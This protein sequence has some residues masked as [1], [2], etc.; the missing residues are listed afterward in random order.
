M[1]QYSA[2]KAAHPGHLLFFRMGDFY[3]LFEEDAIATS[4]ILQITLTKR[5]TAKEGEEGIP[6][7]GVPFHAAEGYIAT[8]LKQGLK[9]ALAEQTETTEQAKARGGSTALVKREVTRLFTPGTLTEET[10]LSPGTPSYLAAIAQDGP[11]TALATLELSTGEVSVRTLPTA[12]AASLLAA[13]NAGEILTT[14]ATAPL[15]V[16]AVG[17]RRTTVE[18][19]LFEERRAFAAITRAY[20]IA[21][22]SGLGVPEGAATLALGAVLGYAEVTQF[23]KLPPL[24]R[25]Q[26]LTRSTTLL[27]DATTQKNLEL[28]QSQSGHKK[29]SL[30]ASITRTHTSPGTRLLARWMTEPSADLATLTTR[31]NAWKALASQ[32]ETLVKIRTHLAGAGDIAR[33]TSRLLLG[34]GSPR[35]FETLCRTASLLPTLTPLLTPLKNPL[36]TSLFSNLEGVTQLTNT[37]GKGLRENLPLLTR[38]GGFVAEGYDAELDK[39]I[40]LSTHAQENLAMLEEEESTASGIGVKVKYNKVW[41]Y[42]LE[43]TNAQLTNKTPLAHWRHRQT[44]TGAQRFTTPKLI[45]L[46][47]ALSTAGDKAIALELEIFESWLKELSQNS[48]TW[49]AVAEALATLDALQSA[50]TL[51]VENGWVAPT[52]TEGTTLTIT[53]GKHPVVAS[54]VADFVPNDVDLSEGK[55]W[56]LTGPN[57]AGKSTFLR[58]TALLVILAQMGLPVPATSMELG[59]VDQLFSRI[60]AADDLARGQ[61]TFMVEMAETAH[62]LARATSKS[63]VILDEVG[64]GT[65]TYDGLAIAWAVVEDIATRV[66]ARTLFATHYHELTGL[67]KDLPNVTPHR[68]AVKEWKGEIIFLHKVEDGAATGSFGV[69]VARL[70]GLPP[71]T[72]TRAE[73]ILEG[74]LKSARGDGVAKATDLSLF[75]APQIQNTP[76]APSKLE[77]AFSKLDIDALSPKEALNLLYELKSTH[78]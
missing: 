52:L 57:M 40:G 70:A 25:P 73:N 10:M 28:I 62:I 45:E 22:P 75:T 6:M 7:C 49:L 42:Y 67:M 50:A 20:H 77:K 76:A 78:L 58:Q 64:R 32:P 53:G 43:A 29:H 60:G 21:E 38:N 35:D 46:E 24:R 69:H 54:T 3:E 71:H 33:A 1:Q 47:Q 17:K 56:L 26:V 63:L 11:R 13:L 2:L 30:L 37:L 31:Q 8:L 16:Q 55:F 9:V 44:T 4:E 14:E 34:R 72:V 27:M 15:A 18:D 51:A 19:Y 48:S 66:H 59:L 61:S 65:A 74:L 39:L 36:L 5:R 12:H 41:G 23:G 68:V